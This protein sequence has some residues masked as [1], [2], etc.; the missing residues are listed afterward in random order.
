MP[1]VVKP[2]VT[3]KK[4]QTF[5]PLPKKAPAEPQLAL[6]ERRS[7]SRAS[8]PATHADA[9]AAEDMIKERGG[10]C[11][12]AVSGRTNYVVCGE[13]LEDDTC[14]RGSSSG[15]A[16]DKKTTLIRGARAFKQFL[17][18][19]DAKFKDKAPPARPYQL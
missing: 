12:G 14:G 16:E 18:D 11:T 7:R 6:T 19:A 17:Q 8:W 13:L 1:E 15:A 2:A 5:K 9:R 10:K 3:Q 4:E